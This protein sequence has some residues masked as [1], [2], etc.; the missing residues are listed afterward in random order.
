MSRV[1]ILATCLV[2]VAAVASAQTTY[3]IRAWPDDIASLP[4]DAFKK[5]P[6]GSWTQVAIIV[7]QTGN[8]QLEGMTFKG[9]RE[10]QMLDQKCGSAR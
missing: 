5:N 6:D 9:G 8:L 3:T 4:C 10:G 2:A 7:V 1:L